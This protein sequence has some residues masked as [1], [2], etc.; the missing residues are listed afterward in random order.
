MV[1]KTATRPRLRARTAAKKPDSG[2]VPLRFVPLGGLEEVGRNCMFFEYKN[3]IVIIDAGLQ[4]P[5]DE[6]PGIDYIIPNIAYLEK[7][8][9]NIQALIVTHAHY[10]HIGGIPHFILKL[11]NPPIY[12]TLLSKAIL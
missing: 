3:E 9:E 5:E 10:D 2:E 6:T 7:K 1:T 11:G 8:K 12:A 4:F